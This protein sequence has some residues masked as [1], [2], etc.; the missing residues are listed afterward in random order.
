MPNLNERL[1][2]AAK[3]LTKGEDVA[4]IG[5]DHALLPI[6][7][8]REGIANRVIACDIAEG[9]L[10][11]ARSNIQRF[12]LTDKIELRLADGLLGLAPF[13]CEQIT[14]CGMGGETIA[15]IIEAA[16][17][18]STPNVKLI[19]QPMSCDDRLRDFLVSNQFQIEKERAVISQGRVYTVMQ[20]SYSEKPQK[21][22]IAFKYI[23]KLL[24][25][26]DKAAF[27]F[28]KR[29]LKSMYAC[30]DDIKN[31]TR[32]KDLFLELSEAVKIIEQK[33]KHIN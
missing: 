23:G 8:I 12:G 4:D 21:A 15:E 11:V 26:P 32:K 2:M 18:V 5:T 14:I 3:L 6:Y 24:D 10:S 28:I 30:I 13:E 20:A 9:P 31:V 22:D 19:L 25:T 29:R 7:L 27:E 1:K 33:I 17:W 16:L